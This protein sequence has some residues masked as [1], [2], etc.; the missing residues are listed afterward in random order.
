MRLASWALEHS[1]SARISVRLGWGSTHTSQVFAPAASS[2]TLDACARSL[3]KLQIW[4]PE[5][6]PQGMPTPAAQSTASFCKRFFTTSDRPGAQ[7]DPS[8]GV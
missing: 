4:L 2:E 1:I 8:P 3:A 7:P 6:F 5:L